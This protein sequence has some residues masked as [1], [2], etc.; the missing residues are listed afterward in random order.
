MWYSGQK[1]RNKCFKNDLSRSSLLVPVLGDKFV[2]YE[3]AWMTPK[4][5]SDKGFSLG[6]DEEK[7]RF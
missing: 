6:K 4:Y 5:L 1:Y 2:L 7:Q 3:Y